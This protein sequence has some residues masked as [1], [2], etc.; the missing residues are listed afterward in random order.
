MRGESAEMAHKVIKIDSHPLSVINDPH[1]F[2]K[3]FFDDS[4]TISSS[5]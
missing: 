4:A 1:V 3:M 5:V 2:D